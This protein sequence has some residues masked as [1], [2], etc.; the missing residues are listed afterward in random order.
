M[1]FFLLVYDQA[2]GRLLQFTEYPDKD[3]AAAL[4]ARF[5][6]ER[7]HRLEPNLEV[8]LLGAR[9]EDTLRVTHS[10]YFKTVG[11]LIANG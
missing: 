1:A 5:Q 10:R 4:Q 8:V 3:R 9:D 6:L 7:Q 11:E 2:T